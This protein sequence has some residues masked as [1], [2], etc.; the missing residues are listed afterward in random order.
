M[1]AIVSDRQ[2]VR[3]MQDQL[4]EAE[5]TFKHKVTWA[6]PQHAP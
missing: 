4:Q 5:L 2:Q 3:E 6:V 1:K